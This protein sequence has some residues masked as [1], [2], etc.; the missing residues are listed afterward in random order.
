M[1]EIP[2]E[3]RDTTEVSRTSGQPRGNCWKTGS[4]S[5]PSSSDGLSVSLT[6][7]RLVYAGEV[8]QSGVSAIC[9]TVC[10]SA[11]R[12]ISG[13]PVVSLEL[14]PM[15][16]LAPIGTIVMGMGSLAPCGSKPPSDR[17]LDLP[18]PRGSGEGRGSAWRE[19]GG[20]SLQR[21]AG[22]VWRWSL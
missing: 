20:D 16:A 7:R 12:D 4:V 13:L 1:N 22:A 19:S 11:L 2:E 8:P 14:L 3:G 17:D 10:L 6:V 21:E 9:P 15:V 5:L 18:E